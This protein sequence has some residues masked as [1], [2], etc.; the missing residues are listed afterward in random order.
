MSYSGTLPH[1]TAVIVIRLVGL[2][3]SSGGCFFVGQPTNSKSI[4]GLI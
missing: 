2:F 3:S 4:L 1:P